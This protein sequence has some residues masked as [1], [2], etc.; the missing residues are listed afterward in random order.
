MARDP[1]FCSAAA[2]KVDSDPRPH[3][4][5]LAVDCAGCEN[6]LFC[7]FHR[8]SYSIRRVV[9][10]LWF[11]SE[12]SALFIDLDLHVG[13]VTETVLEPVSVRPCDLDRTG[14]GLHGLPFEF[15]GQ[16]PGGFADQIADI[17]SRA[18]GAT[19]LRHRERVGPSVGLVVRLLV[20]DDENGLLFVLVLE[21]NRDREDRVR[22]R[23]A[24][25]I[26]I[27]G[28]AGSPREKVE[29]RRL[30]VEEKDKVKRQRRGDDHQLLRQLLTFFHGAR[31]SCHNGV[32]VQA[33]RD[34]LELIIF[35]HPQFSAEKFQRVFPKTRTENHMSDGTAACRQRTFTVA[36]GLTGFRVVL[37]VAAGPLFFTRGLEWVALSLWAAAVALDGMDG[38]V[39]RRFA[40]E[41][42]LGAFLDPAADKLVMT[43]VYGAIA[44]RAGSF[45]VWFLFALIFVRD[46]LVT[47]HRLK[48]YVEKGTF[49]AADSLGKLKTCLQG[50]GALAVLCY[51]CHAEN[52][53]SLASST[54]AAL[55]TGVGA[56]SYL[57]G[58]RYLTAGRG[59]R[60]RRERELYGEP[61]RRWRRLRRVWWLSGTGAS[62]DSKGV[63]CRPEQ[64]RF[65][66]RQTQRHGW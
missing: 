13:L 19:P 61:R 28:R 23:R 50:I 52:G 6:D 48:G 29:N 24:V 25:R 40:Q 54:A 47:V 57:S 22:A 45:V 39:A 31:D 59:M 2:A 27:R 32:R 18:G 64:T 46:A 58:A 17:R 26:P 34:I 20:G 35:P 10:G 30:D 62:Q 11:H 7:G 55:F 53:F 4:C 44:I 51:A 12:N 33:P 8:C 43:V 65:D 63:C 1:F 21:L 36:N 14:R 15:L 60:V 16:C 49:V 66:Y 42:R 41:S 38:W 37:G 5:R 56:L 9:C 3:L